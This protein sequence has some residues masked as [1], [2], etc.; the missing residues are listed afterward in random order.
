MMKNDE[1]ND[2]A[3]SENQQKGKEGRMEEVFHNLR[4]MHLL[5][6]DGCFSLKKGGMR[7]RTKLNFTR[8]YFHLQY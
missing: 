3:S 6:C 7:K 4:C 2:D 8:I 1:T 5:I